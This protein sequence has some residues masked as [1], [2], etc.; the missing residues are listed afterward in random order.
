MMAVQAR[1]SENEEE[2]RPIATS[3][4]AIT[5]ITITII[6]SFDN[7]NFPWLVRSS[8]AV[9]PSSPNDEE[10]TEIADLWNSTQCFLCVHLSNTLH[11]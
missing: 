4:P 11:Q 5:F 2:E 10:N 7:L 1:K 8:D 6:D 3:S 9:N